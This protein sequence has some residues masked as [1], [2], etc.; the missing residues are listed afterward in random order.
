MSARYGLGKMLDAP[1]PHLRVVLVH[2][3]TS[4]NIGAVAR[5]C[6]CFG[7]VDLRLVLPACDHLGPD[8]TK[9]ATGSSVEVLRQAKVERDLDSAIGD[10]GS[11]IAF[12]RRIGQDRKQTLEVSEIKSAAVSPIA[13]VFGNEETG[14]HRDDVERCSHLC[15]IATAPEMGSLNLSHAVAIVLSRIHEPSPQPPI[16]RIGKARMGEM[17]GFFGHC[18][19]FLLEVGLDRG[20][21]PE[22][23]MRHLRRIFHRSELR[24]REV[25]LLRGILSKAQVALGTKAR[26]KRLQNDGLPPSQS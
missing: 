4:G 17:E 15:A 18:Q 3:R 11:A 12:S 13:L 16:E 10:C 23:L 19:E 7:V 22:R 26:G 9:F 14:L 6:A 1:S 20:G 24:A 25:R 8:A 2:P 5:A 21:N